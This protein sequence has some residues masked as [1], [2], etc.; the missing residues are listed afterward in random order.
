MISG[1]HKG[2]GKG[3]LFIGLISALK[4]RGLNIQP[5]KVGL[6]PTFKEFIAGNKLRNLDGWLVDK[7]DM[8]YLFI[9]NSKGKDISI[10]KGIMGLYDSF[11]TNF[12][13]GSNAYIAKSLK[14]PIILVVDG[15]DTDSNIL[16]KIKE[17]MDYDGKIDI[18]GIVTANVHSYELFIK[19]KEAIERCLCIECVGYIPSN[20]RINM[21]Q[22]Y[23]IDEAELDVK[24]RMLGKLIEN[25]VDVDKV[26]SIASN[27][28]TL[29]TNYDDEY[30]KFESANIGVPYDKAFNFYYFDNIDYLQDLGA[31]IV[32]FSPLIDE[33]L[34][35]NLHGIYMGGGFPE[36]YGV[37]LENNMPLR[38]EIKFFADTYLPIYAECGGLMY[39]T[40]AINT[41]NDRRY[42][43]VG[44]FDA[45]AKMTDRYQGA[46][47]YN[48]MITRSCILSRHKE[49]VKVH[50]FHK[51]KLINVKEDNYAYIARDASLSSRLKSNDIN[52]ND[53]R[54]CGLIKNNVL[55]SYM[56]INFYSNKILAENFIKKCIEFKSST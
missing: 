21:E 49:K 16:A 54:K 2:V 30:H 17:F 9:R 3:T 8:Q 11:P 47:Y 7:H 5:F 6:D 19:L 46:G 52:T 50:E 42:E 43:M 1:T 33:R 23:Y 27:V 26:L 28:E 4:L 45:E 48:A 35:E 15:G 44:V 55:A 38:R 31:N 41:I 20:I 22:L 29:T 12:K 40:K 34:P 18:K 37:Q 51:S 36:M 10:I 32:Y 25:T 24:L 53:L 56:H 14:C 39:L 13:Q